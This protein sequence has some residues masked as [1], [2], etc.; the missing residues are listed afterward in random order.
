VGPDCTQELS[1]TFQDSLHGLFLPSK[2]DVL[3]DLSVARPQF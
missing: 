1:I 2:S 3:W